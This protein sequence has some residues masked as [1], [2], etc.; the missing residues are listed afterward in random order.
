MFIMTPNSNEKTLLAQPNSLEEKVEI[1]G[2]TDDLHFDGDKTNNDKEINEENMLQSNVEIWDA[3]AQTKLENSYFTTL[4]IKIKDIL[5]QGVLNIKSTMV[6]NYEI[7]IIQTKMKGDPDAMSAFSK[8]E[9]KIQKIQQKTF[10]WKVDYRSIPLIKQLFDIV[11]L[12]HDHHHFLFLD[13]TNLQ[14]LLKPNFF[15]EF[16]EKPYHS[17][18]ENDPIYSDIT[19]FHSLLIS[20]FK[21]LFVSFPMSTRP[22][23]NPGELNLIDPFMRQQYRNY[24]TT[25]FQKN[26]G[27]PSDFNLI[28]FFTRIMEKFI[29]SGF[30]RWEQKTGKPILVPLLSFIAECFDFGLVDAFQCDMLLSQLYM[31]C[32]ILSSLEVQIK[33]K[34]S[35]SS[36]Q[37]EKYYREFMECRISVSKIVIHI[38]CVYCDFDF[39]DSVKQLQSLNKTQNILRYFLQ[40]KNAAY[41]NISLIVLKYLAPKLEIA[42]IKEFSKGL[43]HNISLIFNFIGD[44]E[45]D[46]FTQST[47][48]VRQEYLQFYLLS[49]VPRNIIQ[50]AH[51]IT[52]SLLEC[53]NLIKSTTTANN[54]SIE[55]SF[56]ELLQDINVSFESNSE[57]NEIRLELTK[58]NV[59]ALLL[60]LVDYLDRTGINSNNIISD[61][62]IALGLILRQNY[63]GQAVLFTGHTYYNYQALFLRQYLVTMNML[64]Y[65]FNDDYT[66]LN[67]VNHVFMTKVYIYKEL[68]KAFRNQLANDQTNERFID[69]LGSLYFFNLF[70]DKILD[71][72]LLKLKNKKRYDLVI[73]AEIVDVIND[74]VF[75]A[76]FDDKYLTDFNSVNF[77][78]DFDLSDPK[79]SEKVRSYFRGKPTSVSLYEIYFSFLKLFNKATFFVY[80]G[81]VYEKVVNQVDIVNFTKLPQNF[82]GEIYLRTEMVKL[83]DRFH[84]FFTN[85]LLTKRGVHN[86][87][88]AVIIG[89]FFIPNNTYDLKDKILNE[90]KWFTEFMKIPENKK[91]RNFVKIG[92]Y[93]L[94]G[95][96]ATSFKYLKGI[97]GFITIMLEPEKITKLTGHCDEI[98]EALISNSANYYNYIQKSLSKTGDLA[99]EF[100]GE[101]LEGQSDN[102]LVK[103]SFLFKKGSGSNGTHLELSSTNTA[104]QNGTDQKI[105]STFESD[106]LEERIN[107]NLKKIRERILESLEV[108]KKIYNIDGQCLYIVNRYSRHTDSDEYNDYLKNLRSF[109]SI[110]KKPTKKGSKSRNIESKKDIGIVKTIKNK[111]RDKKA[112]YN[113]YPNENRFVE[114]LTTDPN[115]DL[116]NRAIAEFFVDQIVSM[117][118]TLQI[119]EYEH[120]F[121]IND[122]YIQYIIT[123]NNLLSW[124]DLIRIELYNI[125]YISKCKSENTIPV[126]GNQKP[127]DEEFIKYISPDTI[128]LFLKSIWGTYL[129]LL[130]FV[131]FK[132]FMD[133]EWDEYW[134]KFY[135]VSE[136]LQNF[137][138]NNF[139]KFKELLNKPNY[140]MIEQVRNKPQPSARSVFFENYILMEILAMNSNF[141]LN[142]DKK[143]VPSDR[144]EIFPMICR[145]I[146]NVT[147]MVSGPCK[148]NQLKIY[149]FRIDMWTGIINRIV[150]DID[151]KL[152]DV[153]LA[154]LCYLSALMEGLDNTIVHFMGSNLEVH[155]LFNLII[156]L[157]RKLYLKYKI[158]SKAN[159][160]DNSI[161][162]SVTEKKSKTISNKVE[163]KVS[164]IAKKYQSILEGI[165]QTEQIFEMYNKY[166]DFSEHTIMN[167]VITTFVMIKNMS[168]KIKFYEIFLKDKE[169]M[170]KNYMNEFKFREEAVIYNFICKIIADIEIVYKSNGITSLQ[171]FY[172]KMPPRCFFLTSEM[173]NRFMEEST[174]ESTTAKQNFLYN[175]I[176]ALSIEMHENQKNFSRFSTLSHAMT[177]DAFKNYQLF[178]ITFCFT[179]NVILLVYLEN[180]D[181]TGLKSFSESGSSVIVILGSII[182]AF[183][184]LCAIIWLLIKYRME[185]KVMIAK[186]KALSADQ[187]SK[188][189]LFKIIFIQCLFLHSRFSFFLLMFTF[190]ILGLTINNVFFTL[191]LLLLANISKP[192]NYIMRSVIN[193]NE[194][195]LVTLGLT[196]L[197]IFSYSFI[198]LT[199]FEGEI[200]S[201]EYGTTMCDNF[202]GCFINSLNLGLRLDGGIGDS[203][204]L[205]VN[206]NKGNIFWARFFFDL[207]FFIIVRL[208]LLN[209]IAGIIIDT[210]SDLRDELNKKTNDHNNICYICGIDRWKLEQKGIDFDEHINGDHNKWKY[211]Y[212]IVKLTLSDQ[213]SFTGI[214]F[215][216]WDA[217]EKKNTSWMPSEIYLK[218][219]ENYA[220]LKTKNNDEKATS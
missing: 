81:E 85:H 163:D 151:S 93:L 26:S 90:I 180:R 170:A 79:N 135:L 70:F 59:P 121:Y 52:T 61:G 4:K 123:M 140:G 139:V 114:Y 100:N 21:K 98:I 7:S 145:V 47:S 62:I 17:Y 49:H 33:E 28:E 165:R 173:M 138:E 18:E 96:L 207:T 217:Y 13:D 143:I 128:G 142:E 159:Q 150:D 31:I 212:F 30:P 153:K 148:E 124:T 74:L 131:Y 172:F 147:E 133:Q 166:E 88:S 94:K 77:D 120:S 211:L 15:M 87:N 126:L 122:I 67:L 10:N 19:E 110:K 115:R 155:K 82:A 36:S 178:L 92:K 73:A 76:I 149:I 213:R 203:L 186:Q 177:N 156:T 214:E 101:E 45:N 46:F 195:I 181:G 196:I 218:K 205:L 144:P 68:I 176:E 1:A 25:Y 154:C 56:R 206:T 199:N 208:I 112:Y 5:D 129:S 65:V 134:G 6:I 179:L 174:I 71:S 29:F 27:L 171:K 83:F 185:V 106:V 39:A 202:V 116:Y 9:E 192:V 119:V 168:T 22:R 187:N 164:L 20:V 48:L 66:M 95:I 125:L 215:F 220:A 54:R 219:G 132:T 169:K 3:N 44:Y 190:S 53:I 97:L 210:F 146:E 160:N 41:S 8:I 91:P 107:P 200:D 84:V 113:E 167:I 184:F 99:L 204:S 103:S 152:Y 197:V 42:Q 209:V 117:E 57:I 40:D 38:I 191:N 194:K 193:H 24:N 12:I 72:N 183:S 89:E 80:S 60:Q 111:Y 109:N 11:D 141:W 58:N 34:H 51:G 188:R 32:E 137:C 161:N 35:V 162:R 189:G 201:A 108:L 78:Y 104:T 130:M 69:I 43:E 75:P 14:D 136:L 216:V 23:I 105:E 63:P 198:L 37:A 50:I 118:S 102:N 182:A 16:M 86:S 127:G 157:T 55:T 158:N 2:E 64:Q 175:N